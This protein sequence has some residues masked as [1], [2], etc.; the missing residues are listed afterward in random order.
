MVSGMTVQFAE[1]RRDGDVG[2][3][4][5][6]TLEAFD[7][8]EPCLKAS[9]PTWTKMHTYG[10]FDIP[11]DTVPRL[12]EALRAGGHADSFNGELAS[13]LASRRPNVRVSF[14]GV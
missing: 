10:V 1:R 11:A 6:L 14:L 7:L 2:A 5:A 9:C 3:G 13:W 12:I 4:V 8:V